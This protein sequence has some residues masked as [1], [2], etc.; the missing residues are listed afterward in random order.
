MRKF[1]KGLL[2]VM[3]L[4]LMI[5]LGLILASLIMY[6][7]IVAYLT[8]GSLFAIIIGTIGVVIFVIVIDFCF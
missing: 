6:S 8:F 4:V 5:V 3:Y 1:F 2:S 7:I